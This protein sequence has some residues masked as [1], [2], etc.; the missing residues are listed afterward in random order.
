MGILR[1]SRR[2]LAFS[3]GGTGVGI[4]VTTLGASIRE[5]SARQRLPGGDNTEGL[6]CSNGGLPPVAD[7]KGKSGGTD[8]RRS[9]TQGGTA[10]VDASTHKIDRQGPMDNREEVK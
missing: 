6:A 5:P 1:T 2:F 7:R 10:P 4:E 9:N 3:R 8:L